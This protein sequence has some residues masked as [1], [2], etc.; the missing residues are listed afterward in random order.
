MVTVDIQAQSMVAK[1]DAYEAFERLGY[2]REDLMTLKREG[3]QTFV[4]SDADYASLLE[5][6]A[7][8]QSFRVVRQELN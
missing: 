1:V 5:I 6:S 4:L 3:S 7:W 8:R 2:S